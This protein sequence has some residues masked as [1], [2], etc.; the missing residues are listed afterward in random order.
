[1]LQNGDVWREK[2]NEVARDMLRVYFA[3][4]PG[5]DSPL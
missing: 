4:A 5:V 1:M 3:G 2:A